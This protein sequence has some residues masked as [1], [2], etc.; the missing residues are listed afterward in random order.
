MDV[1]CAS[2]NWYLNKE[3]E[4][5]CLVSIMLNIRENNL[6]KNIKNV[7]NTAKDDVVMI[8]DVHEGV[9]KD[10][11]LGNMSLPNEDNV[12]KCLCQ[13]RIALGKMFPKRDLISEEY[14]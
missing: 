2:L 10:A 13:M 8:K 11:Y 12:L 1:Q 5:L 6:S 7:V 3:V 9:T 4:E 14:V